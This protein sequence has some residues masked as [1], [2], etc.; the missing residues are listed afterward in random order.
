[1]DKT[2]DDV[3]L[4]FFYDDKQNYPF[5]EQFGKWNQPIKIQ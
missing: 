2:M 5:F 1:M 4:Y 3:L